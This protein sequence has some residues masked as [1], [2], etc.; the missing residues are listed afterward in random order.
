MRAPNARQ[1]EAIE[2]L[3]GRGQAWETFVAWLEECAARAQEQ[4]VRADD[5]NS[6]R[7]LQGEAR[8]LGDLVSTLKRKQ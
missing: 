6:I 2:S 8:C 7:R 5:E 1:V 3:Q 4:C